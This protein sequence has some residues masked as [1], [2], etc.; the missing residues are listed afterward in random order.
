MS[1]E[2]KLRRLKEKNDNIKKD[3][4]IQE[5]ERDQAKKKLKDNGIKTVNQAKQ[6]LKEIDKKSEKLEDRKEELIEVIEEKL[7]G[8]DG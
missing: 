3:L 8:Y 1:L 6:R 7:D 2:N 4:S 5:H